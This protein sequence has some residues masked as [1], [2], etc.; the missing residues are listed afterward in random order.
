MQNDLIEL[1]CNITKV[2]T[3]VF[4]LNGLLPAVTLLSMPI[5]HIYPNR[6]PEC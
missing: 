4:N 1:H 5:F 6:H 3:L 2:M